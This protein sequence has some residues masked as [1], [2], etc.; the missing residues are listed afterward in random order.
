[1]RSAGVRQVIRIVCGVIFLGALVGFFPSNSFANH[2]GHEK[3]VGDMSP[4]DLAA[5]VNIY[6]YGSGVLFFQLS[7]LVHRNSFAKAYE[8]FGHAL[9][10][11]KKANPNAIVSAISPIAPN[12]SYSTYPMWGYWVNVEYAQVR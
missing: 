4:A 2:V 6:D 5:S 7:K 1:M 10:A 8:A 3:K 11:Y 9:A 12:N